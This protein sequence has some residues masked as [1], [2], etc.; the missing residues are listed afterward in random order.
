[1]QKKVG[2]HDCNLPTLSLK[3]VCSGFTVSRKRAWGRAC[4]PIILP[5]PLLL[6]AALLFRSQTRGHLQLYSRMIWWERAPSP[7]SQPSIR[8][9]KIEL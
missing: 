6:P 4:S 7:A 1:M 8:N 9:S 2:V 3:P 5:L